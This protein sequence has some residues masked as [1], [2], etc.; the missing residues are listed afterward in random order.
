MRS[1][2]LPAVALLMSSTGCGGGHASGTTSLELRGVV[3][4]ASRAGGTGTGAPL[5]PTLRQSRDPGEQTAAVRAI[6]CTPGK[7]EPL[8]GHDDRTLPLVTCGQTDDTAYL[9]EPGFLPGS[10]V[11]DAASEYNSQ[12]GQWVV[13]LEFDSEGTKAWA[14]FTGKHVNGQAAFVL[15]S[16]VVSVVTIR[17]AILDGMAQISGKFTEQRARDLARR[18]QGG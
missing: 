13:T 3:P 10:E 16:Q 15:D 12:L 17:A 11:S 8:A 18:I 6:D 1:L 7:A 4:H 5:S 2:F 14:G 9:L